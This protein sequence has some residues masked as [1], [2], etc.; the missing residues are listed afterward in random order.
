[1]WLSVTRLL[2]SCPGTPMH[3]PQMQPS[4][5]SGCIP[6][7]KATKTRNLG[8]KGENWRGV[9]GHSAFACPADGWWSQLGHGMRTPHGTRP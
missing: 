9:E 1:M 6:L 8:Q 7:Q 2:D 3:I 4:S 5:S